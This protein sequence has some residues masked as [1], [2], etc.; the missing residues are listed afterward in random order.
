MLSY[1]AQNV[2]S[3]E[4]NILPGLVGSVHQIGRGVEVDSEFDFVLVPRAILVVVLVLGQ[5]L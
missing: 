3:S 4:S 1:S 2:G 5:A